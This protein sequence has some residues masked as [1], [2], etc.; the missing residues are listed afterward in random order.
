MGTRCNTSIYM[1]Y[2][3]L[4][5]MLRSPL[6]FTVC[7]ATRHAVRCAVR[8]AVRFAVRCAV[9]FALRVS[10]YVIIT[11]VAANRVEDVRSVLDYYN[12]FDDPM[13]KF[14][15]NQAEI[16]V[17]TPA[18]P[19]KLTTPPPTL[20][21]LTSQTPT[22]SYMSTCHH[23]FL[24]RVYHIWTQIFKCIQISLLYDSLIEDS[25]TK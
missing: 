22:L 7:Y 18:S 24:T 1:N 25:C 23:R 6:R 10:L 9:H 16:A 2:S 19:H 20:N 8:C 12:Q 15:E 3:T 14:R 5:C 4:C 13:Q 11:A 21:P 17:S